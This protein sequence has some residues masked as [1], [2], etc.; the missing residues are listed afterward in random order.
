M[1]ACLLVVYFGVFGVWEKVHCFC[2]LH[3]II[4]KCLK[5]ISQIFTMNDSKK[6]QLSWSYYEPFFGLLTNNAGSFL[7]NT[8]SLLL[9][10]GRKEIPPW[11]SLSTK[12]SCS[13][14]SSKPLH[15]E[16]A[17]LS[18]THWT[19]YSTKNVFS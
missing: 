5:T 11:H 18:I 4:T 16:Q 3:S 9:P 13:Q 10:W 12:C 19:E 7:S 8:L 6:W 17:F 15:G 14:I 1:L 2:S